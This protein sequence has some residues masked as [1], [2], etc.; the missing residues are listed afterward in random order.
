MEPEDDSGSLGSEWRTAGLLGM[1]LWFPK[2]CLAP[3]NGS[4]LVSHCHYEIFLKGVS[5]RLWYCLENYCGSLLKLMALGPPSLTSGPST[6]SDARTGQGLPG[7]FILHVGAALCW[8]YSL[9]A[10]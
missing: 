4:M 10:A 6:P 9:C 1:V 2:Q 5:S 3:C 7:D 8:P